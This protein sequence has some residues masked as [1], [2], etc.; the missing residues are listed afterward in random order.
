M[1]L[2]KITAAGA[3]SV[4][5]D[6]LP[7]HPRSAAHHP[8]P[9][10]APNPRAST[11]RALLMT[12]GMPIPRE[13]RGAPKPVWATAQALTGLAE[14]QAALGGYEM[15]RRTLEDA[16][17]R[18][19]WAHEPLRRLARLAERM[20]AHDQAC[21]HWRTFLTQFTSHAT[22]DDRAANLRSLAYSKGG[23]YGIIDAADRA[24]IQAP[25]IR[26]AIIAIARHRR[27]T[28]LATLVEI[29][30]QPDEEDDLTA[31]PPDLL[32]LD[33]TI[34]NP[35][36]LP[37][38]LARLLHETLAEVSTRG[39]PLPDIDALPDGWTN[40]AH[41][42]ATAIR[43]GNTAEA[44][45]LVG[46]LPRDLI[47]YRVVT[48]LLAWAEIQNERLTEANR[49][50]TAWHDRHYWPAFDAPLQT[51]FRLDSKPI[52]PQ[53]H[54][55]TLITIAGRDD[56][57]LA[58]FIDH[59]RALGAERIIVIDHGLRQQDHAFLADQPDCHLFWTQD[60]ATAAGDGMRWVNHVLRRH[61]HDGWAI[62]LRPDQRLAIPDNLPASLPDLARSLQGNGFEAV[63]ATTPDPTPP[64]QP[65]PRPTAYWML[66]HPA[67]GPTD[68][69]AGH[70][71]M[72]RARNVRFLAPGAIMPMRIADIALRLD[73]AA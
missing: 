8:A 46:L 13:F 12:R 29:P 6:I 49:L 39:Q 55:V 72:A 23:T 34:A 18:F 15:A 66:R 59:H 67:P 50:L 73:S 5:V 14:S 22:T 27:W 20:G 57:G 24:S 69:L 68:P 45:A 53:P 47:G 31:L 32:L 71:V 44:I 17:D 48:D 21:R 16:R 30:E 60:D 43:T 58:P 61:L 37:P 42:A 36:P 7:H 2:T 19:P 54:S 33:E 9:A 62:V 64:E 35:S 65:P 38:H 10:T 25:S 56:T 63:L 26:D 11:R 41:D 70:I 40:L 1:L 4:S 51:F 3:A 28:T 52:T